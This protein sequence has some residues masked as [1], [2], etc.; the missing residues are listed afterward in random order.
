MTR[1]ELAE[2][3]EDL[4]RDAC[5]RVAK[6]LKETSYETTQKVYF[7]G[8]NGSEQGPYIR[9]YIKLDSG[10]GRAY[11][12]VY[13]VQR[14]GARFHHLPMILEYYTL[15]PHAVVVMEYVHG[16]TLREIVHRCRPS[17]ALAIDIFPRLCDAVIELHTGFE[18]PLIHR[19]LTPSNVMVSQENLTIIDFGIARTFRQDCDEDTFCFGTR[20]YAPPEQFGF[21]QTDERSDVYA[22][23]MLF[24]FCLTERTPETKLQRGAFEGPEVPVAFRAVLSRATELDPKLRFPCVAELKTAFFQSIRRSYATDA[25]L[26][27]FR[28]GGYRTVKNVALKKGDLAAGHWE[29][30]FARIPVGLGISWNIIVGLTFV[31]FCF[32]SF[33]L[34]L[35]P[36]PGSQAESYSLVYRIVQTPL[37][38]LLVIAPM[39]YMVSDRRPLRK[40][41]PSLPRVAL[42]KELLLCALLFV[43][44][45]F[46]VALVGLVF[47]PVL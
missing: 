3:L 47:P 15:E 9:K 20:A 13:A 38:L 33:Q 37:V 30:L 41:F 23:G 34:T 36:T 29:S 10:L 25:P 21:G 1:D 18:E 22:L 40:A 39:L 24:Y 27:A 14:S 46:L 7:V 2:H 32:V 44:S 35:S 5:Y 11:A 45:I 6:T 42:W 26:P 12:T 31:L 43:V 19:D 8:R 16:E 17:S 28:D 4:A